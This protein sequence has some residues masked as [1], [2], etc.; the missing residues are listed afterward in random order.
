VS[1]VNSENSQ[2]PVH[3][4]VLCWT[5]R[6]A[7]TVLSLLAVSYLLF[8]RTEFSSA[9][10]TIASAI[11]VF[12]VSVAPSLVAWWSH[13]LGGAFVLIVCIAYTVGASRVAD[14]AAFV[15]VA[16]P[17]SAVWIASGILHLIV[18]WKEERNRQI[19]R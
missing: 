15:H 17:F 9:W 5:A 18:S 3:G 2:V 14:E 4:S 8:A 6:I 7:S 16:I 11:C 19:P 13:R 12:I 10:V 1:N